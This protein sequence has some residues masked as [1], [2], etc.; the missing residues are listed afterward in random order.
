[1]HKIQK[2][3]KTMLTFLIHIV[4]I[5]K[6]EFVFIYHSALTGGN[7]W[8]QGGILGLFWHSI[9]GSGALLED[10]SDR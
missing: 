1:M 6:D 3:H 9:G 7:L 8:P 5:I 10:A 2:K 4:I